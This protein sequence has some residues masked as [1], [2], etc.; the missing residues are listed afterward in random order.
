[1]GEPPASILHE[2]IYTSRS[3]R[4]RSTTRRPANMSFDAILNLSPGVFFNNIKK[5]LRAVNEP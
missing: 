3:S 1:M 4:D 2:V 5:T